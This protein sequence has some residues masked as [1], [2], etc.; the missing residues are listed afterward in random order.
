MGEGSYISNLR[1]GDSAGGCR[2]RQPDGAGGR[3]LQGGSAPWA[4]AAW[5][6]APLGHPGP[7]QATAERSPGDTRTRH[8]STARGGRAGLPVA[9]RL[10]LVHPWM[11]FRGPSASALPALALC[12]HLRSFEC[13][14]V[15]VLGAPR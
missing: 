1:A 6:E 14:H 7:V 13:C 15:W 8:V 11:C 2:S 10:V 5:A 12:L 3:G 9:A 4:W